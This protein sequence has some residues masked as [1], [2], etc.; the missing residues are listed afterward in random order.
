MSAELDAGPD[1]GTGEHAGESREARQR[2]RNR[3]ALFWISAA[4]LALASAG[5]MFGRWLMAHPPQK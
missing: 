5:Y 4:C 2:A 1:P 3:T